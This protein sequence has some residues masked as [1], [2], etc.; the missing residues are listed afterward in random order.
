MIQCG[1][2]I[3]MYYAVVEIVLSEV[4]QWWG[5][6]SKPFCHFALPPMY[7]NLTLFHSSP[8]STMEGLRYFSRKMKEWKDRA[9]DVVIEKTITI[10]WLDHSFK[11]KLSFLIHLTFHKDLLSLF[12]AL[13]W[14]KTSCTYRQVV[15][16]NICTL[17]LE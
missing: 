12:E 9:W 15:L 10:N 5:L 13:K 4:L 7:M 8:Q 1:D 11:G 17:F 3:A 6:I 2:I 14:W 16:A